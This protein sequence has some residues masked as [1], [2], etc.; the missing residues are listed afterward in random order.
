LD[1]RGVSQLGLAQ[2][3]KNLKEST[4]SLLFADNLA[5]RAEADRVGPAQA[6]PGEGAAVENAI[7]QAALILEHIEKRWPKE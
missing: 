2:S 5:L 6:E 7:S 1:R 3:A 4:Q